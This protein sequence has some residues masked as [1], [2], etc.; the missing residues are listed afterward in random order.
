[1]IIEPL[2]LPS[3]GKVL[4]GDPDDLLGRDY[5]RLRA[6]I[7]TVDTRMAVVVNEMCGVAA[8]CLVTSW[9]VPYIQ[10]AKLPRHDP[11]ILDRLRIN[12]L[13]ALYEHLTGFCSEYV[14]SNLPDGD[15]T[16]DPPQP[17]SE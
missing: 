1:M 3:G 2:E 12:D 10:A 4:F 6:C 8:E 11:R 16:G 13:R 15:D 17:A 5:K 14:L 7:G 9:D